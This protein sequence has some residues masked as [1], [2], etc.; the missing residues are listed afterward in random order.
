ME[1]KDAL[2]ARDLERL[3]R[4]SKNRVVNEA[5]DTFC[6][7]SPR[8]GAFTVKPSIPNARQIVHLPPP[9]GC[10]G[11]INACNFHRPCHS[12]R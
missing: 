5:I 9:V 4:P 8:D 3:G 6:F 2:V 7:S 12:G 1:H 10:L 11:I